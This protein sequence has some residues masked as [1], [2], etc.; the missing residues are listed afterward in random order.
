M[1][2]ETHPAVERMHTALH[3]FVNGDTAEWQAMCSHGADTTLF[4]G[5]G[6]HEKGWEQLG[7]RY[8][9]AAARF[10][11]GGSEVRQEIVSSGGNDDFYYTVAFERSSVRLAGQAEPMPMALRVTHIYRRENGEWKL[12][13][14][15]ADPLVAIQTAESVIERR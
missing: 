7:P 6:G 4:G 12:L 11:K 1:L 8:D 14:R 5:W 15:H 10:L 13:H 2:A 3:E 9:W